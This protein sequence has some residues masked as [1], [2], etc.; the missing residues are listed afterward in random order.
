[1]VAKKCWEC[2]SEMLLVR[3][4]T[5]DGVEYN[6]YKCSKC[7][8]EAMTSQQAKEFM[9]DYEEFRAKTKTVTFSKWGPALG[10]RIPAEAVKTYHI[11]PKTK[12][13]L[14][15]ERTGFKIIPLPR[16]RMSRRR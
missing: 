14:V 15:A 1:M 11:R 4:E 6:I 12:G 7:G 8:E 3:E 10:I 16:H 13:M 2:G 9:H 5:E